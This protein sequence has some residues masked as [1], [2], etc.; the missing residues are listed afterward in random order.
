[1]RDLL[2]DPRVDHID[3]HN[4]GHGCFS[5]RIERYMEAA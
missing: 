1:M 3:A 5:A 2:S 4:A